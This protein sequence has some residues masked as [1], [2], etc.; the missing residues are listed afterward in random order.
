MTTRARKEC[1]SAERPRGPLSLWRPRR[2]RCLPATGARQLPFPARAGHF[3]LA[4]HDGEIPR[5]FSPFGVSVITL[6]IGV[7]GNR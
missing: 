1:R 2:L 3:E 6:E 7:P 4:V 5:R